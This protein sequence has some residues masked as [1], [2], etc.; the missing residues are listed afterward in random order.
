M[1]EKLKNKINWNPKSGSMLRPYLKPIN[2]PINES[3]L[4]MD[5]LEGS[6]RDFIKRTHT[7]G[8][9]SLLLSYKNTP[10]MITSFEINKKDIVLL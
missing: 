7:T 10:A 5:L 8:D 4:V 1:S 2:P 3:R 6:E 9:F